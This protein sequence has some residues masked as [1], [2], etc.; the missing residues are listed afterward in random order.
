MNVKRT[1]TPLL[2][3]SLVLLVA[4]AFGSSSALGPGHPWM[5]DPDVREPDRLP[6][7]TSG[8][9]T[10]THRRRHRQGCVYRQQRRRGAHERQPDHPHRHAPPGRDNKVRREENL[11]VGN[12]KMPGIALE[13]WNCDGIGG[14]VLTA[15][16]HGRWVRWERSR[17]SRS[18]WT[19]SSSIP[20]DSEVTSSVTVSGGGAPVASVTQTTEVDP[21][22]PASLRGGGPDEL[23]QRSQRGTGHAGR[24]SPQRTHEQLRRDQHHP[25]NE[26][27][28]AAKAS[29]S[30]KDIVVDLPPGVVGNPQVAAQCPLSKILFVRKRRTEADVSGC[31]PASRVGTL[32]IGTSLAGGYHQGCSQESTVYNMIPE[33]NEPAEFA[34]TLLWCSALGYTRRWSVRAPTA[35]IRV[36][37]PGIPSS[38]E[39]GVYSQFTKVLR[40]SRDRSD[41]DPESPNAFFTNSS[42]CEGGPLVTTLHVDSYQDP[43]SWTADSTGTV[44]TPNFT[45]GTPD[46]NEANEG[47]SDPAWKAKTVESPQVSGL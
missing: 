18:T 5:A 13:A 33:G 38:G 2:T 10:C 4:F 25:G 32:D 22:I 7:R 26:E 12:L 47:V 36:T 44:G 1:L 40:G 31:P 42:D 15:S 34:F 20:A 9:T 23:P 14:S 46:F 17:R 43:G 30:W 27:S 21:S 45:D 29:Q 16:R 39:L 3:L 41:G 28:E 6:D 11:R 37:V 19:V 8:R 24:G 35:H